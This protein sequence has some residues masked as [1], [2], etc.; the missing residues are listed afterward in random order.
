LPR[1][2]KQTDLSL[3]RFDAESSLLAGLE[4][5]GEA[6]VPFALAG[7]LAVW[8]Y[9]PQEAQGLT[10]DVDFAVLRPGLSRLAKIASEKGFKVTP[11]E[12]GG[13]AVRKRGIAVDFIDRHPALSRLFADAIAA[14]K[15][16]R[17]RLT[18]GRFK[19]PVVPRN[20]LICMKLAT[21][22]PKDDRDV[23]ELLKVTPARQYSAL[24]SLVRK[25]HGFLGVQ[26]LDQLARSIGHPGAAAVTKRY[27]RG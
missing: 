19:L 21:L 23:A 27:K 5:L 22:E 10:K 20:H 12:I 25:Y 11:L 7:R 13:Y 24:R 1:S 18:I 16:Q 2:G 6:K 14:A 9:V 17:R 8:C 15:K 4:I 3:F 26:R